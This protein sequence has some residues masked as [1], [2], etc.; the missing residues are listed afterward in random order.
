MASTDALT[1]AS[2]TAT[3]NEIKTPN[4]FLKNLL[5]GRERTFPTEQIE[6]GLLHGDRVM[7]PFVRRDGEA[8]MVDGLGEDF[9]TIGFPTIRIKRPLTASELLF[10]RRPG[11]VVFPTRRQ[12]LSAIEEH[13]A[14]DLANMMNLVENTEEWLC[15]KALLGTIDYEAADESKF[16]VT[17]D[18]PSGHTLNAAATWATATNDLSVD[19]MAAKRLINGSVGLATTHAIMSQEAATN[20]IKN[21]AI[22]AK[23]DNRGISIGQ[24]DLQRQFAENGA[25]YLGRL[26]G[27]ECWEYSRSV[28]LP[29]GTTE[30]LIP[31]GKVHF[32]STSRDADNWMYYGA[33]PD[34][35]ALRGRLFQGKRFSKS[36]L[37]KDPSV[38]Q[39]LLHTRPLPVTRRP[40]FCVTM[41]TTP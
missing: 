36:W 20:F 13:I 19:F 26:M 12:Q 7:A 40:G 24:I 9:K 34:M 32:L 14:R 27:V 30:D 6:L 11:T 25:L 18:K 29:D 31:A 8:I 2:M 39:S 35:E 3:V 15:A 41:D 17:F 5:F 22:E 21:T 23:L 16:S 33:I 10:D 28:T 1:W 38:Y 4:S 37:E